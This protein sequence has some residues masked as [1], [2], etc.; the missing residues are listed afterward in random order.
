MEAITAKETIMDTHRTRARA[1]RWV[2]AWNARDLDA[3]VEQH[4]PTIRF[5]FAAS[6]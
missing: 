1:E 6:K 3:I 4:V 2:A 5:R